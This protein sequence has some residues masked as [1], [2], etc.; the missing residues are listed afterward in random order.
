MSER[1]TSIIGAN[2]TTGTACESCG[3]PYSECTDKILKR[4]KYSRRKTGTACCEQ[5]KVSNT[6]DARKSTSTHG[7]GTYAEPMGTSFFITVDL[8]QPLAKISE[9]LD[10]L[11]KAWPDATIDLNHPGGWNVHIRA[12]E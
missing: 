4:G 6:H 3:M 10:A 5:C 9:L 2:V 7:P 12:Q 8:P 11:G 1:T